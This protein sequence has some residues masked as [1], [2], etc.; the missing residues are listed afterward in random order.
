VPRP[1]VF[2]AAVAGFL[3]LGFATAPA[4]AAPAGAAPAEEADPLVVHIDSITPVLPRSGDVEIAGT[5]TNASDET[6]TRV[7]VHAFSSQAPILTS[8]A[9]ADSAAIDPAQDVG[10]RVTVPGTFTTI[11]VLAPGQ[12]ASFTDAVP[13]ELLEIPDE[14]GIYWIGVH[15]LGD[16]SI[17]RDGVADGRARTFIPA[18]P[19]GDQPQEASVIL[20]LRGR[21]WYDSEGRIGGADRWARRLAEGGSLDGVLDMA[22]SAGSTPYSWLVDPAILIAIKRLSF[23]N[24]ERTLVPD[25]NV[26][27]QEPAPAETPS[28]GGEPVSPSTLTPPAGEPAPTP[29]EEEAALAVEAAEWLGRF[30]ALVGSNP[31]LTLPFG[32]LDV[33][34]AVRHAPERYLEA[35][36]R[37]A[38]VM[39]ELQLPFQTAVAPASDVLSPEAISATPDNTLILLGD[40]AFVVPPSSPSSVVRLLGHDVVV[41]STGAE[42]GGPGP[43][44]ANDPLALRQRLLSEAALRHTAGDTAPLVV[45]LPTVWRGEDAAAF[46]TD[47]DQ[48]WLDLVPVADVADRSP[49]G[50]P[51]QNLAYTETDLDAELS[52]TSFTL[53]RRA[54]ERATLLEAVL[55]LQTMIEIQVRDEVLVTLSELHRAQPRLAAAA[56]ARVGDELNADLGLIRIE[57]PRAVT[58]SSDTGPLGATLVNGLDQPVTV[59]V[60]VTTDGEL[61]LTGDSER[62]LAPLARSVLRYQAATDQ[63]GVHN[64]RLAVTSLDGVPLGSSDELPIRAARVSALIWVAMAAGALVLFGMI[65]YRLPGQVRARRA[66][67][68]AAQR[69]ESE[70]PPVDEPAPERS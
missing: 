41:T 39:G 4:L 66:E 46:F 42:A 8:P 6:F 49:R 65:G 36:D 11:D 69:T 67:L 45:T 12:T 27:G 30:R 10:P 58:L 24:P 23:G 37:S 15:A 13:V 38:V 54:S 55:A 5:V 44:P 52:A 22:E 7:N 1:S 47:L 16:S 14:A 51:A 20:S 29:S 32:D 28:E 50:V 3:A 31:V 56:T 68:A 60:R 18:R 53:A 19:T 64:V 62:R 48:P 9:L 35:L 57:A 40:N 33:S 17:P 26:P 61:T 59:A 34:A 25:P 63:P 2:R 21:V 70:S 43:T